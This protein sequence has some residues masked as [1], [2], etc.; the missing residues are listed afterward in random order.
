MKKEKT[1]LQKT[2]GI[3]HHI[4]NI[5]TPSGID[6]TDIYA[7]VG[8]NVGKIYAVSK[9]P[10]EGADFGWLS[11]VCS[12]E[13]TH[14]FI[15]YRYAE[16]AILIKYFDKR[17]GEMK[18]EREIA[19]EESERRRLDKAVKDLQ[20][21]IERLTNKGESVGYVNIMLLVQDN[22]KESLANRIKRVSGMMATEGFNIRV[23]KYKQGMA[24]KS[25]AP[26]GIPDKAVSIMGERNMPAS[27]FFG[28]FPMAASGISDAGGHFLAKTRNEKL[29]ILNQWLR[30]ADRVNS[31]WFITGLP[32]SGKSSFLKTLFIKE[33]AFGTKFIIWD[34]EEE[35]L[36]LAAHPD[37]QGDVIDCA[38]GSTGRINPLQIRTAP[39]ITKEDLEAG[40]N[41]EDYL[42]YEEDN[43]VS[44]M[45]LHIQN[46]RIFFKLYFGTE[47]FTAD[48]KTALEKC[49]VELYNDFNI[50]W[51]TDIAVL[52]NKDFPIM[53]DLYRKVETKAAEEK[54]EY[55]KTAYDKL[56]ALLYSVHDGADKF[57]WNGA[58]TIDPKSNFV[59]LNTS[60]LLDLDD[61]VKRAQYMNLIMWSWQRVA[62]DRTEKIQLG[63]DEGYLV[64]DPEYIEV[65]KFM[66]NVSKRTRKY[67]S[68]LMF[69]THSVVDVLDPEVKRLGQALIDNACYKFIM[70]CDG[71]N[72]EETSQLFH[73]TERERNIL[74]TKV[75]GR[76]ILCAGSVRM[77][78]N[79]IIREKFLQMMGKAGGR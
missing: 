19:K 10:A 23:L 29:I 61:N 66:R 12:L 22:N 47:D 71:K 58:T 38:G 13:G 25:A 49:L 53:S 56:L 3:N 21:M 4:L 33:I 35:Y 55:W 60:K 72:L 9:Y 59:V 50:S 30:N 67:E 34:P 63:V 51:E 62:R 27:S 57:I 45:A 75:R 18:A 78:A 43:D 6:F 17:I 70:G 76:G 15:E 32:G 31:N 42:I 39:R 41:P 24:L 16:S 69:I 46:L 79:I 14:T 73:L 52:K 28:G 1:E 44:D 7:N 8:D 20:N 68:G 37:I 5:I 48:V 11:T 64:V 36:D 65:L 2:D 77:E 40:E 54:S 74:A 26:Y